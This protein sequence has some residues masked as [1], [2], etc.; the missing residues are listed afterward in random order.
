MYRYGKVKPTACTQHR[1]KEDG[2]IFIFI[3]VSSKG[4]KGDRILFHHF[5]KKNDSK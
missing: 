2:V 3:K 4:K 5:E 1:Y